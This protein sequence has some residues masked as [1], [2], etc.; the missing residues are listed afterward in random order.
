MTY[1]AQLLSLS[2]E[3]LPLPKSSIPYSDLSILISTKDIHTYEDELKKL[4][5]KLP[6]GTKS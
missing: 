4:A 5:Q 2:M 3:K 1:G 6:Y